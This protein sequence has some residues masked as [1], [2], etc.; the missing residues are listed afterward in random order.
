M[1]ADTVAVEKQLNLLAKMSGLTVRDVA[2]DQMRLW[3]QDLIKRTPPKS[4]PQG[5]RAIKNDLLKLFAPANEG[6]AKFL[7][8][9]YPSGARL[10]KSVIMNLEGNK[11]RMEGF[12]QKHRSFTGSKPG[13]VR[14]R[15]SVVATHNN[16][17]FQNK[18]YVRKRA[19]NEYLRKVQKKV[20]QLKAGWKVA[21]KY[22][23]QKS[24]GIVNIPH[25]V[26]RHIASLLGNKK[27]TMS[28]RGSGD[29]EARNFAPGAG[30]N[31]HLKRAVEFTQRLRQRDISVHAEKRMDKLIEQFNKAA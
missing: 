9:D 16:V 25:F 28:V 20:G 31:P 22:Y 8:E 1:E 14:Y 15:A 24:K 13:R 26:D 27:D 2:Y 21:A 6:F 5:K 11:S 18:M 10:P 29:L 19:F 30:N 23:E 17:E 3:V 12:H 4:N 7:E